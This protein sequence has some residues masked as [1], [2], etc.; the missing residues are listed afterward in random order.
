[1]ASSYLIPAFQISSGEIKA[2]LDELVE[3]RLSSV[4]VFSIEKSKEWSQQI[5]NEVKEK[6]K[7]LSKDPNYKCWVSVVIGELKGQGVEC[8]SY[9]AW[10]AT[11]DNTI[12]CWYANDVLYWFVIAFVVYSSA[13]IEDKKI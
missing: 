9:C 1:M 7:D 12:S 13:N 2:I 10:D 3:S 11:T 8:S 5:G 4:D 6:W